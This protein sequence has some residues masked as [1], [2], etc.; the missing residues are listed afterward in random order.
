MRG[1]LLL[2]AIVTAIMSSRLRTY[3]RTHN[4]GFDPWSKD[5]HVCPASCGA[6]SSQPQLLRVF[7]RGTLSQTRNNDSSFTRGVQGVQ[8]NARICPA[9]VSSHSADKGQKDYRALPE[10]FVYTNSLINTAGGEVYRTQQV[11][12]LPC[13]NRNPT[14]GDSPRSK[15]SLARKRT[16]RATARSENSTNTHFLITCVV[17]S[18]IIVRPGQH[19]ASSRRGAKTH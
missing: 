14:A 7:R 12:Q 10:G 13:R 18:L 5:E 9:C 4:Y 3:N 15:L 8:G 16:V 6:C 17:R 11:G 1:V 2:A 19:G